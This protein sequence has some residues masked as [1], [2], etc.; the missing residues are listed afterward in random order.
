MYS[1]ADKPEFLEGAFSLQ[2]KESEDFRFMQGHLMARLV[3]RS[4]MGRL[5][6]EFCFV[7]V[8][9][10]DTPVARA[11]SVPFNAVHDRRDPFPSAGWDQVVAWAV[12]D[13]IDD[14]EVDTVCALEIYVHPDHRGV[15]L[16]RLLLTKLRDNARSMGFKSLV[17][18]VRPPTKANYP[19]MDMGSFISRVGLDGLP[20]DPW[21]R[22][23]VRLGGNV[24]KVCPTSVSVSAPITYWHKWTRLP[25]QKE[26]VII[27]NGLAPVMV[28]TVEGI[29]TYVEPNVW[30]AHNF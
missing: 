10:A 17:A 3:N 15:G 18:P 4:R 2:S 20:E 16:S 12:E 14:R 23:H 7:M 26:R 13:K 27:P 28:D 5:W 8:D 22:T 19:E 1:L 11:V 30:V 6:P 29:A 25:F 21:L 9:S 24:I